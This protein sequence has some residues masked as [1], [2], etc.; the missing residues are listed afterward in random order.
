MFEDEDQLYTIASC[1]TSPVSRR[2]RNVSLLVGHFCCR[3]I[4]NHLHIYD[5]LIEFMMIYSTSTNYFLRY[6]VDL[7]SGLLRKL[8]LGHQLDALSL[9]TDSRFSFYVFTTYDAVWLSTLRAAS[10]PPGF[11]ISSDNLM[12]DLGLSL[13]L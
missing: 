11:P 10:N 7:L 6:E 13:S 12:F 9:L 4:V 8:Y 3:F 5:S 1:R 2:M